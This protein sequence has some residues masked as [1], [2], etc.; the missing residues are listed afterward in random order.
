MID[1]HSSNSSNISKIQFITY[2]GVDSVIIIEVITDHLVAITTIT[3]VIM[4]TTVSL[5]KTIHVLN[6]LGEPLL[7]FPAIT[8]VPCLSVK[9]V[10]ALKAPLI[11]T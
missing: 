6:A 11:N 7:R 10:T 4:G 2:K 5:T 9:R 3:R 1:K 8:S